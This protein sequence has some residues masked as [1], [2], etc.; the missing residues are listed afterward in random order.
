M[1]AWLGMMLP[2]LNVHERIGRMGGMKATAPAAAFEN[3]MMLGRQ[4]VGEPWAA[5]EAAL[6]RQ[7]AGAKSIAR[8]APA[9]ALRH[10]LTG[11]P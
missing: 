3:T 8:I 1:V 9:P 6:A 5:V 11:R 4:V 7:R 2:A 10:I